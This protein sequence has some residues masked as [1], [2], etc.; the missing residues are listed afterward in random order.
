[1]HVFRRTD[2]VALRLTLRPDQTPVILNIVH[3]DLYFFDDLD[4]IQLN[5]EVRASDLPLQ[6]VRDILFRFGRAYPSG[7]DED[8]DGLHNVHLA[9]WLGSDGSVVARSDTERREKYLGFVCQH[10]S[11]CISEH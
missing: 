4:L 3:T 11:P 8:G 5:V 10:R 1:M 9:E 7:W 6:T 2:I